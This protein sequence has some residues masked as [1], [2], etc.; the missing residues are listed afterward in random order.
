MKPTRIPAIAALFTATLS[1][2]I[3]PVQ[4]ASAQDGPVGIAFVE[5]AEQ[6]SGVCVAGNADQGFECAR[7]QCMETGA[8]AGDCLRVKWCYP[9]GWSADIFMQHKEGPHWHTY[10]CGWQSQEDLDAAVKITCEG[11]SAEY[12]IECSAVRKWDSS[13]KQIDL[14]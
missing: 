1:A 9:A 11:S 2:C 13:G 12:L 4:T 3:F 10:L 6:S 14:K 8:S 7:K 5:A